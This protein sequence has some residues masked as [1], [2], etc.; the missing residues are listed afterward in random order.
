LSNKKRREY[1]LFKLGSYLLFITFSQLI[2]V[3]TFLQSNFGGG[4]IPPLV[5]L[6][7][8]VEFVF[9]GYLIYKGYPKIDE[10]D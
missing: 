4:D 2:A 8:I 5:N 6:I 9:S 1:Q 7:L 10:L 3:D